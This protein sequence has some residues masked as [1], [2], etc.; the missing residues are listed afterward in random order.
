MPHGHCYR[1]DPGILW[2]SV[3]SDLLIA[4]AYMAIPFTL[5]FQIM[6][7]RKD[8][9]F[10]W[11]F[12]CFG[13][14]IV[15]CGLTHVMEVIT[16]WKP[17]YPISVLVKAITAS[18]SVPT[19][20]ILFRIAPK[21]VAL[22]TI[23]QVVHE[24][25][26]RARAEAAS[27]AKDRFVA[28]LSH[29]LRTPLMPVKAG[30]ELIEGELANPGAKPE[31]GETLAMIRN[32]IE[33]EAAL[34]ND[35]L[36]LSSSALGKLRL[37]I[38]PID[39]RAVVKESTEAFARGFREK[40]IQLQLDLRVE[41][42]WVLGARVRLHQIVSN[43]LSNALKFTQ[44]NG[45]IELSLRTTDNRLSLA[46]RDNGRGIDPEVIG[47]IF[48]PFVQCDRK[49]E[50][51]AGLGLG[52]SIAKVLAELHKGELHAFSEGLGR[53]AT[54]TLELPLAK[55]PS[56]DPSPVQRSCGPF[57]KRRVLVVDDHRDTLR[58][59]SAVL[60]KAGHEVDTAQSVTEADALLDRAEIL[61]TDIGL[62]D[63]NGCD[64]MRRFKQDYGRPGIAISG[65][66]EPEDMERSRLAGFASHLIKPIDLQLL[67]SLLQE[68]PSI[69]ASE[70]FNSSKV[71]GTEIFVDPSARLS[72]DRPVANSS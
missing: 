7:K 16:V 23:D 41:N 2:T 43:L 12:I 55:E 56:N 37:E 57:R 25:T 11:M 52:L 13:V 63:G 70:A 1:W 32:N 22:P 44:A 18:A 62:P 66:G 14:F 28:I 17:Y 38:K 58:A 27:E 48:E 20:I 10:N 31:I 39:L 33:I 54:F 64:L 51:A 6:R 65:F 69:P 67:K 60:R 5:V 71:Q 24:R 36:D 47:Q 72:Y 29:E 19:A 35:L 26:L 4:T 46:V 8:L 42:P 30:L 61:V 15:A 50:G 53:G 40:N 21:I 49:V 45:I 9:P 68:V 3:G 34:I 59:L